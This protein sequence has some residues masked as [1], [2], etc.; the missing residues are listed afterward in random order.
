[1]LV[2][3]IVFDHKVQRHIEKLVCQPADDL[4][5]VGIRIIPQRPRTLQLV[6]LRAY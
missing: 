6:H 3:K 5:N 4:F 2:V 1:M